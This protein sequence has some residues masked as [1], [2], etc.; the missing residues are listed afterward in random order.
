MGGSRFGLGASV[1]FELAYAPGE[2][3]GFGVG[4]PGPQGRTRCSEREFVPEKGVTFRVVW[5]FGEPGGIWRTP[6]MPGMGD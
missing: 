6:E 1:R 5:G 2:E 4:S 3:I